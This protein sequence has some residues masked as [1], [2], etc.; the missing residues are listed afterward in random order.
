[1]PLSRIDYETA[2]THTVEP[3]AV[4]AGAQPLQDATA[5]N[6]WISSVTAASAAIAELVKQTKELQQWA[7][8]PISASREIPVAPSP[9]HAR[10]TRDATGDAGPEKENVL[11]HDRALTPEKAAA[12]AGVES[13]DQPARGGST[14]QHPAR[15]RP[16]IPLVQ[17][18]PE[19]QTE[20]AARPELPD[21]GRDFK[22]R[23]DAAQDRIGNH[24]QSGEE[25]EGLLDQ[26]ITLLES[27]SQHPA[28]R[29]YS[30]NK[31]KLEEIE[32]RLGYGAYPQ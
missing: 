26:A 27:I 23:F 16:V 25:L 30:A 11:P 4:E 24:A 17:T 32:Q 15:P 7:T 8:R 22:N 14:E 5:F 3:A 28:I 1:M 9:Q 2:A 31:R 20:A 6:P 10:P 29:E 12:K 21:A 13:D 18:Q 19:E